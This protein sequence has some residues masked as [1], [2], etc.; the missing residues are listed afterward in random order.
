[1]KHLDITVTGRVQGVYF[2][3]STRDE[4]VALGIHGFVR[5]Q[6][7]G[8]VYLEVEGS[9]LALGKLLEWLENGPPA[10][11]VDRV[12]SVAGDLKYFTGFEISR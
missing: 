2:R 11:R 6:G 7:D 3:A 9:E 5:N 8:S 12:E 10:A 1:M 4:A